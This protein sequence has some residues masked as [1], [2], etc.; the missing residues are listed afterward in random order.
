MKF[1]IDIVE[2]VNQEQF[3]YHLKKIYGDKINS[4]IKYDG[5]VEVVGDITESQKTEI[6]S[7]YS[8]LVSGLSESEYSI[9]LVRNGY[10]E[11]EVGGFEYYENKRAEEVYKIMTG[12]ISSAD[13][14]A[15]HLKTRE[16]K[17]SILTGDWVTAYR[18][19][20]LTTIDLIYTQEV[21][22]E[23]LNDIASYI[24]DNYPP[25]TLASL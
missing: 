10:S 1:E 20:V 5:K 3:N 18:E 2:S 4:I 21:K 22:D 12:V 19:I 25:G 7:Y 6:E 15:V 14:F 24:N 9:L 8:S 11:K 16:V 23:Y 17:A 13:A